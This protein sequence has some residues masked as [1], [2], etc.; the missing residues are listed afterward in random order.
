[1]TRRFVVRPQA[2]LEIAEAAEWYFERA[3][4]LA[5]EFVRVVDAA[6]ATIERNPCS[7]RSLIHQFVE[8]SFAGFLIAFCS[9]QMM[10]RLLCFHA[11]TR[12]GTRNVGRL[13]AKGN[14]PWNTAA[15]IA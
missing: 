12:A 2:D 7:F 9:Q 5:A 11:S 15:N 4:G 8:P 3:R 1:M 13:V 6:S 14:R 10:L